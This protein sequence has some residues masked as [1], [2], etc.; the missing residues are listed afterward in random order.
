MLICEQREIREYINELNKDSKGYKYDESFNSDANKLVVSQLKTYLQQ[1]MPNNRIVQ[2]KQKLHNVLRDNFL[3]VKKRS[4]V[5]ADK[6]KKMQKLTQRMDALLK[7][8]ETLEEQYAGDIDRLLSCDCMSAEESD[9]ES[10]ASLRVK[11][12]RWR[13]DQANECLEAL[14]G[15]CPSTKKFYTKH[16]EEVEM[17]C[18][19]GLPSWM[20]K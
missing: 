11:R 18:P 10:N 2:A 15:L 16:I 3:N 13:S 12:P 7:N 14:D 8:R 4:A 20:S 6:K 19:T 5:P 1:H 17:E 9:D